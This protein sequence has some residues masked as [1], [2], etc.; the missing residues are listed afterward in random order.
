MNIEI[1][2]KNSISKSKPK[3]ILF[4]VDEKFSIFG[5]KKFISKSEYSYTE[6]LLKTKD[7]K[8]EIIISEIDS[9]KKLILVS[10]KKN[11]KNFEAENLGAKFYNNL[12]NLK[13]RDFVINTDYLPTNLK[14]FAGYFL[15]GLKL[16]S[17][18]FDKYKTKKNKNKF[19]FYVHG[20][21]IPSKIEQKRFKSIEEGTF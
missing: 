13:F 7:F 16:K 6:D 5:I 17:Y 11:I 4:F 9:K 10:I 21:N 14:N 18:V 8:N 19:T 1:N 3:N 15:H 2:Y 20:K 12:K